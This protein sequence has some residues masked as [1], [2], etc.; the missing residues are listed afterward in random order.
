MILR[1]FRSTLKR[2]KPLVL[3]K[4]RNS[5]DLKKYLKPLSLLNQE[6]SPL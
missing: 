4:T 1:N 5:R 6:K 2:L 3:L